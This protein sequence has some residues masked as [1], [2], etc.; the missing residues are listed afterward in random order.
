MGEYGINPARVVALLEG[1]RFARWRDA[2]LWSH[3]TLST[4]FLA[5]VKRQP[6]ATML[7]DD[8]LHLS[9]I[10]VAQRSR[11][12]AEGL[13]ARGIGRGDAIAYQLPHWWEATI[14][15][16]AAQQLGAHSVPIL[17]ILRA[18]EFSLVLRETAPKV[19]FARGD[20]QSLDLAVE[21][22]AL[23]HPEL[24]LL[25]AVR[26]DT[27]L[28]AHIRARQTGPE[29][30]GFEDLLST[31]S[32]GA[33][34][35]VCAVQP[36]DLAAMIYT[37]GATTAPKGMLH[38]QQTLLAAIDS[39]R[40][41][42]DLG[43]RDTVLMPSPLSAL[44]GVLHG[45]LAP[46]LLGTSAVLRPRWDPGAALA[47]IEKHSVTYMVGE[48]MFL[49]KMLQY[50]TFAEHGLA[51]LRLFCCDRAPIPPEL[52]AEARKRLPGLV[53]Q[54]SYGSSEFPT[55]STT[56]AGDTHGRGLNSAGKAL[57]GVEIRIVTATGA[58]VAAGEEGEVRARGPAC[59]LGYANSALDRDVFDSD[60][61]LCT[62]DLGVLDATGYLRITGRLQDIIVRKGAKR[63]LVRRFGKS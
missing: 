22:A 52:L 51:S 50:P 4:R 42:H 45:I 7:V 36:E 33:K 29:L 37:A 57:H 14:V 58:Q 27:M 26:P 15:F 16:L 38:I 34:P 24:P 40:A 17:P 55:I 62:G 12:L 13:A 6:D 28:M 9:F 44:A 23:G 48:P 61:F 47:A 8:A 54:R 18:R 30:L 60:D 11:A 43:P 39:L 25:V 46:A 1:P 59:F 20:A 35:A 5:T 49:R 19:V 2:G 10:T 3:E 31:K 41:A 32:R 56:D 21:A 53:V 63:E